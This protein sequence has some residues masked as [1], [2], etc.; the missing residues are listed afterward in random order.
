MMNSQK[1][2][3]KQSRIEGILNILVIVILCIQIIIAL[4]LSMMTLYFFNNSEDDHTYVYHSFSRASYVVISFFAHFLLINTLIP[5]SLTVTL[6]IIKVALALYIMWDVE[7]YSFWKVGKKAGVSSASIVEELGQVHYIFSDKTGTLTR[8]EMVFKRSLVN[9]KEYEGKDTIIEHL[10]DNGQDGLYLED[11]FTAIALCH[12]GLVNKELKKEFKE[13]IIEESP[14]RNFV[15][16]EMTE[17][18]AS[19]QIEK[20][21]ARED[22]N[23]QDYNYSY[24][25]ESP[26]EIALL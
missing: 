17:L 18:K 26:D 7:M 10:R 6:E 25:S 11:F 23:V 12:E 1:R 8:N 20:K 5:I 21:S 24:Q 3:E 19:P 15:E 9:G 2:H 13:E 22:G 14:I 4:I 16:V